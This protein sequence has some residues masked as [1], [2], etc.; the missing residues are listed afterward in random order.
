MK[1]TSNPARS[2]SAGYDNAN[3]TLRDWI[4]IDKGVINATKSNTLSR[5]NT[6]NSRIPI[7]IGRAK[8]RYVSFLTT[9]YNPMATK[10]ATIIYN[11]AVFTYFCNIS[12]F[13]SCSQLRKSPE[14]T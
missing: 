11:A 1:M 8:A 5:E 12:L 14:L 10:I 6:Y 13:V 9:K 3:R 2:G 7:T 4:F